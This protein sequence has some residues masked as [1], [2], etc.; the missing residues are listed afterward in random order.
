MTSTPPSLH[1]A[2]QAGDRVTLADLASEMGFSEPQK[3]AINLCELAQ[4]LPSPELVDKIARDALHSA[5]PDNA[6][7]YLERLFGTVEKA[8]LLEVLQDDQR[9]LQL[10]TVLGGSM[11]LATLL[12]RHRAYFP[13]LF[14]E[15]GIEKSWTLEQMAEELAREIPV[16]TDFDTLQKRLRIFKGHQ[17]LRIGARDLCKLAELEEVT[18]ELSNLASSTLDCAVKVCRHSLDREF[19]PARVLEGPQEGEIARYVVLGMGKFGGCELNFSSDID[20]IYVYST[21]RGMTD[22]VEGADGTLRNQISLHQYFLK[23]SDLITKAIGQATADGFIFRVDLRLRPE[24]NNGEMAISL[25]AAEDYYESWGRGWERAAMIKAR[26][27]AGDLCLGQELLDRLKPFVYRRYLDYAMVDDIKGMKQK[28]DAGLTRAQESER[29]IKLGRGGIREIEFFAQALQLI[30]GGK[31]PSLQQKNLLITLQ[32]LNNSALITNIEH[33]ILSNAYRFLRTVEHRIMIVA[34]RQTHDLPEKPS[35]LLALARRTGFP[36]LE[37][38]QEALENH[39]QGVQKIYHSLFFEAEQEL[40]QQGDPELAILFDPT[41]HPDYVKDFLESRGFQNPDSAYETL[42]FFMGRTP[43]QRLTERGQRFL[44]KLAPLLMQEVM[45]CRAPEMALLNLERFIQALK[46]R[47][48]FFALLAENQQTVHVLVELFS[49]SQFL[50]RIFIQHPE[51]LD[52]MV[53]RSYAVHLKTRDR[54]AEE[55]AVQLDNTDDYGQQLECLR[56]YRNEEFLRIALNDLNGKMPLEESAVQ[57]TCLSE[58]ILD[59]SCGLARRELE[60]RFGLPQAHNGSDAEFAVIG[61]GKMGGHELNYHSDLDIIFIYEGEGETRPSEHTD[62]E[63]F[64]SL[65]NK[66]YFGKLAQRIISALTL[67]TREGYAYQIDTQLRPSGNQGPLVTSLK[68]FELYHQETAQPWE[69]MALTKARVVV[70]TEA[71]HSR[72]QACI[73]QLTFDPPPPAD[74][75]FEMRR[76]RERM[77]KEIAKEDSHRFNIKTGHGGMVDVEFIVQ[78]LQ[79]N[80]GQK[81]DEIR[82]ANTQEALRQ[83]RRKGLLEPEAAKTLREGYGFLRMLDN[84][85]RL[86]HDQSIQELTDDTNDLAKLARCFEFTADAKNP[87]QAFL[88]YYRDITGRIRRLFDTIL[89]TQ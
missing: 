78:Y 79:L 74:L 25:Q 60:P 88:E 57:L 24:G 28:I 41:A 43:H 30:N 11:F 63:R 85:L 6:L 49:S 80:H 62:K 70:A 75:T 33:N 26:P 37:E 56:R 77:E 23:L 65:S 68:A 39:R 27:V 12:C 59:A 83:L 76:L 87:A 45:K 54:M 7:N 48:S 22:G 61:M 31:N 82:S 8:L 86:L 9:R 35:E 29:N 13:P 15:K 21:T 42:Q 16:D 5:E 44:D 32:E 73:E 69:R 4:V 89:Q 1:E 10:L 34:E 52:A 38:F 19:G 64:R 58:V 3:T 20:L 2:C 50:S 71:M 84:R 18:A 46:A 72:L 66:E 40:A 17:I 67:M 51:I 14:V 55:L 36:S 53:S 81:L 47:T